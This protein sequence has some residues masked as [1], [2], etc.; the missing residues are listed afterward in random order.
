[1]IRSALLVLL[2]LWMSAAAAEGGAWAGDG[3]F[4]MEEFVVADVSEPCLL[5]PNVEAFLSLRA[6]P[7]ASAEAIGQILP[8]A[9]MTV[10]GW[11]GKFAQVRV[12]DGGPVGYVHTGYVQAADGDW[13][14]W[15]YDYG[16]LL[17]D[18]ARLQALGAACE[19]IGRSADGREILAFRF[20]SGSCHILIQA[21]MHG[22][23]GMSG[24]L[25]ADLLM[26]LAQEHPGGIEGVTFHVIPMVNPDGVTIAVH[27][28]DGLN[29]PSLAASVRTMLAAEGGDFRDWKAN[30]RGV[31][32]NR[33]FP[34]DWEALSVQSPGSERFRGPQPLSEPESIAL[35]E[36]VQAQDFAATVSYHSYGSLIYF[37]GAQGGLQA[38]AESLAQAI[39]DA[40]G[41]P[42]VRN[43]LS[44]V[45]RGG[46]KDWAL[47]NCAVP[48]VTVETGALTGSGSLQ[49]Y[50]AL[51]LRHAGSWERLA[52]WALAQQ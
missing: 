19:S 33:N 25:A 44:T 23:E 13:S 30:A 14:R 49:E 50:T 21:D 3:D 38:R 29:D 32:L 18:A 5:L 31:D 15:P 24:R 4:R 10:L 28:P 46:F 51:L 36:F 27:G 2:C 16:A 6:A 12:G 35:A 42:L 52:E 7:D 39:G 22:R 17:Q 45:E 26:R 48:S 40:T 20:G 1:M 11:A 34:A 43:E 47:M 37:Q 9:E 41:Y 8:G